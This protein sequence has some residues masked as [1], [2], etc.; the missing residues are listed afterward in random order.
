MLKKRKVSF[1]HKIFCSIL[2]NTFLRTLGFSVATPNI[3][4]TYIFFPSAA[5]PTGD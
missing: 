3:Y 1:V 4:L 2:L 5:L